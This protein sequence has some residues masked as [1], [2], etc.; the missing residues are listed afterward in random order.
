[1]RDGILQLAKLLL[2]ALLIGGGCLAVKGTTRQVDFGKLQADV[3]AAAE[4]S[5]LNQEN[6]QL[7]RRFYGLNAGELVHWILYT[8]QDNMSVEELLLVECSSESQAE[9]VLEAARERKATQIKNFEG[10]G[11]EQVQLLNQSVLRSD[12]VYVLF[13]VSDQAAEIKKA[14]R[15]DLFQTD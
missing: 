4:V 8:A 5:G 12:G 15:K 9:Q 7:L 2:L 10:Y 1:M 6:A 13:A 14:Y 11:P 3:E